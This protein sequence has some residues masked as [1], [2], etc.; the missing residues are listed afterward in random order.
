M[1]R[2]IE[3][4]RPTVLALT[5]PVALPAVAAE[6]DGRGRICDAVGLQAENDEVAGTD[7]YYTGGLRAICVTSPRWLD[8]LPSPLDDAERESR[9]KAAFSI[10]QSVFTPDDIA[11]VEPIDDDHP[12]AGWLYLGLGLE[13]EVAPRPDRAG[14]LDR[15]ELQL[16][17]VGP[18]SGAEALQRG[19]HDVLDATE[20]AG[21]GN[22]LDNEPGVNLFCSRQW[23][24]ALR[25]DGIGGPEGAGLALDVSPVIGAALGNVHLFG[26]GGLTVR[27]G[28]FEA[29]DH[30]S[31]L[32]RPSLAGADGFSGRDGFS[33]YLFGGIE[34]RLVGRN[35]FLDGNS[36]QDDGPSVDKERLVG[37]VRVGLAL[38]YERFGLS[39]T[40]VFRTPEFE[41]QHPHS[42]GS[43]TLTL[44]L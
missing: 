21:W 19:V 22:Q 4:L 30:G 17:V 6:G 16:G 23:T 39:Y 38:G 11:Q 37:E 40:Q 8:A 1:S 7:R 9:A 27:V 20:P 26:G 32:I 13:S 31:A 24:G 34:G 44:A 35:I 25:V 33:G 15:L 12:Y 3:A 18:W 36:F 28:R 10:G 43:L 42:Y 2:F 14:Y 5:V 41:G 29:D